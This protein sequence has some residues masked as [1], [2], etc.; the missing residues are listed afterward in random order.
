[1]FQKQKHLRYGESEALDCQVLGLPYLRENLSFF[2]L[3]PKERYGLKN[4]IKNLS[5]QNL[6]D[7]IRQTHDAEVEVFQLR[8]DP[9]YS[10]D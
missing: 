7:A 10:M 4:L 3:L 2:V 8:S 6:L 1:M 5:G 9:F